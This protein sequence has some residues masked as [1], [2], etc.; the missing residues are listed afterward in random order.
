MSRLG[1]AEITHGELMSLGEM[2]E[3]LRAVTT[4]EVR[5][6]AVELAGA[7]RSLVVVGPFEHDVATVALGAGQRGRVP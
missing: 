3:R 2:L 1:R 5:A 6:L 7:P 4:E